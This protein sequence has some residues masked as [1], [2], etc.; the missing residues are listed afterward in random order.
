MRIAWESGAEGIAWRAN[1]AALPP[2]NR[3]FTMKRLAAVGL[4]S[5]AGL[6]QAAD[7]PKFDEQTLDPMAGQVCYALTLADVNGDKQQDVV[8]VTEN[9]VLWYQNP[10]WKPRV[11][12]EDQTPRD[13]VCIA[14]H[15]IDGDGQVDFA[16]GAGWTKIGTLHWLSRGSSLDAKWHVHAIGAEVSTHRMRFADVLGKGQAQLVVSP[17][18]ATEGRAGARLTAFEIPSKPKTERWLGT[19]INAD[20]NRMHNH[21]HLDFDG[22]GRVDTLTASREGVFVVR[23]SAAGFSKTKIGAGIAGPTPDSS[24][25]GEIKT[26]K[27]KDGTPFIVTVEPM[28]GTSVVVYTP[29]RDKAELWTRT[30]LDGTFNRGHALGVADLDRDGNEDIVFGFSDPTK[31]SDQ[32]PGVS[33]F[34]CQDTGAGKWSKTVVDNGGVAVEDLVVD[35]LNGDG[36][37]DIVACGR[38]T[39]NVKLY[40]NRTGQ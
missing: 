15:D 28:H 18:L 5:L 2:H 40:V 1:H 3:I 31:A 24:G 19:V 9:R 10:D 11:I 34:Q 17:L 7:V 13:N 8:V 20:F 12:I 27:L 4:L 33:V 25:A 26:G 16:I 21:T 36:R 37:P 23:Q 22:D 29:P 30:V 38:A 32:K 35:D 39:H 6:A 14:A